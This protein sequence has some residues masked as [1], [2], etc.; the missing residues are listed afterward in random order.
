MSEK[1]S[2]AQL[3]RTEDVFRDDDR[4]P[5][6]G[7]W[8]EALLAGFEHPGVAPRRPAEATPA[9]RAPLQAHHLLTLAPA[10]AGL[11]VAGWLLGSGRLAVERLAT[12]H[13]AVWI[14]CAAVV[15]VGV[16][17]GRGLLRRGGRTH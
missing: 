6:D 17:A 15:S 11:F 4:S 12:L 8:R 16:L 2:L 1:R 7:A 5:G 14:A 9:E 10:G 13:P 3:L